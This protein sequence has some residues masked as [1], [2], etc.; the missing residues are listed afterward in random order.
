MKPSLLFSNFGCC[1]SKGS[2]FRLCKCL[3]VN[4]EFDVG[5]VLEF[6]CAEECI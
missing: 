5:I 3:Y 4:D 6:H 1:I 2:L